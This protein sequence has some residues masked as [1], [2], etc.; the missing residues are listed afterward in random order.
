[1]S[2]AVPQTLANPFGLD[3]MQMLELRM[4][5]REEASNVLRAY[6]KSRVRVSHAY[7]GV[8]LADAPDFTGAHYRHG[9]A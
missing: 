9:G 6:F 5:I 8:D 1:M 3:E 4:L 2:A 7:A